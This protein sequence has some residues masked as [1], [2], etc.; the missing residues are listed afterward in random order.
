MRQRPVA[1]WR[2]TKCSEPSWSK[3][4]GNFRQKRTHEPSCPSPT[5][6][7]GPLAAEMDSPALRG[8]SNMLAG[9]MMDGSAGIDI[10]GAD[11]RRVVKE[12]KRSGSTGKSP[13]YSP[14]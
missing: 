6:T 9:G 11:Y 8:L 12:H 2:A 3:P 7:Y 1:A 10:Q 4:R 5:V 13:I 14:S